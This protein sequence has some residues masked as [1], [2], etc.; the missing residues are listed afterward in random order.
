MVQFNRHLLSVYMLKSINTSLNYCYFARQEEM[1]YNGL[2]ACPLL[3]REIPFSEKLV[4]WAVI[5][6]PFFTVVRNIGESGISTL[7][8]QQS[9]SVEWECY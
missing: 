3:S 2:S 5:R 9:R 4:I 1:A 7:Y 8:R 6:H